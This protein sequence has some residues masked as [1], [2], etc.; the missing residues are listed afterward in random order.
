MQKWRQFHEALWEVAH[1]GETRNAGQGKRPVPCPADQP[2]V[3]VG[4]A[5]GT[6]QDVRNRAAAGAVDLEK[7][8]QED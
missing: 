1:A 2:P 8:T 7:L 3:A 4:T 5:A 6:P